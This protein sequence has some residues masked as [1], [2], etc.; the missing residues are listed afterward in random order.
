MLIFFVGKVNAQDAIFSQYFLVPETINTSFTGSIQGTK[1]GAIHRSQWTNFGFKVNTN[2]AF[3]DTWIGK[4]NSGIGLTILNHTE[5][6]T[7]YSF[8]EINLNYALALQINNDWY[9]RPSVSLGYG[10][11]DYAFQNLLL[12]DQININ[13]GTI[14]TSSIDPTLLNS[15]KQ[16]LDFSSSILF[17]NEKSWIGLT[18]RHL[19]KPNISMTDEGNTPLDIFVSIHS[20]IEFKLF[21]FS[22]D[23]YSDK[24]SLY[25]LS[26]FMK[27]SQYSRLDIGSQYV[28]DNK[29]SVGFLVA[30]NPLKRDS[31]RDVINSINIFAALKWEG[32][33]YGYSYDANMSHIGATGGVHEFSISY[34]F[35]LNSRSIDRYKCIRHF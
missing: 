11:K 22:R 20:A 21:K 5:N 16:F 29:F 14:N 30:S 34:D 33:R 32:F 27:Q 12:E 25:F 15:K 31:K 26:N 28:Y 13:N 8:T 35:T 6:K 23:R 1:L 3:I 7:K 4:T 19:N 18:V 17:N 10:M 2:F 9:F 24:N